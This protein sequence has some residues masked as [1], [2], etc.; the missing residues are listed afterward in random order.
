M[1][2]D[3]RYDP[4]GY[5][6]LE[7]HSTFGS[8]P[9]SSRIDCPTRAA[10]STAASSTA[11]SSTASSASK[12]KRLDDA[13]A[14]SSSSTGD[15]IAGTEVDPSDADDDNSHL[16]KKGRAREGAAAASAPLL[17][18]AQAIAQASTLTLTQLNDVLK[19]T[20]DP[21]NR[22]RLIFI[23]GHF[24]FRVAPDFKAE[25]AELHNLWGNEQFTSLAAQIQTPAEHVKNTFSRFQDPTRGK[26][27]EGWL[28]DTAFHQTQEEVDWTV[29]DFSNTNNRNVR[30]FLTGEEALTYSGTIRNDACQMVTQS[31]LNDGD[32]S[33]TFFEPTDMTRI[34]P[35]AET[36]ARVTP[37]GFNFQA[38]IVGLV[39]AVESSRY[40]YSKSK[41]LV[42]AGQNQR[43][44]IV[45]DELG[46]PILMRHAKCFSWR[47]VASIRNDLPRGA[48]FRAL[49]TE[50]MKVFLAA[51][52]A[53]AQRKIWSQLDYVVHNAG[54][55]AFKDY[56]IEEKKSFSLES[57]MSH[58]ARARFAPKTT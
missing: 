16:D 11:A 34:A 9:V 30:L 1:S 15:T 48:P 29:E 35:S 36:L 28:A 8:N 46:R 44:F 31:G 19:A 7:A 33:A 54:Y 56:C 14:E 3:P 58:V 2:T 32:V 24:Q 39:G 12:R 41:E 6:A 38:P 50:F 4:I 53:E 5:A 25:L 51:P 20:G 13:A 23:M 10:S 43:P 47:S 57:C 49:R 21:K 45:H 18:A 40:R 22:D 26:A 17:T 55:P 52:S 42:A 27:N 37:S